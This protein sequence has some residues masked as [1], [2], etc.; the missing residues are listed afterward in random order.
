MV[1]IIW[2][3]IR[4]TVMLYIKT[5]MDWGTGECWIGRLKYADKNIVALS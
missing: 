4:N 2:P 5:L 1:E 3:G